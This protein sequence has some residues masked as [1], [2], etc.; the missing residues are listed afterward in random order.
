MVDF[1][2]IL[3]NHNMEALE[4]HLRKRV[5][6]V[7]I[8]LLLLGLAIGLYAS[9]FSYFTIMK[10]LGFRTYAWDLGIFNQALSTTL[11]NGRFFYYTPE[12]LVNPSGSFFGIHFSPILF[13]VLPFYA[14]FPASHTLL[15]IQSFI[16]ALGAVPLYKLSID[17][18]SHRVAALVFVFAY[19]L[20]PPLQGINWFDFHVQAFFPLL[21]FS[22]IY[23]FEKRSW[24]TYFLFILFSLMVEEHASL[25]VLFIGVYGLIRNKE[26]IIP[27]LRDKDLKNASLVIPIIT[28]V[29]AVLW[30]LMT[31]WVRD[32]FFPINPNFIY[33]FNA[34]ANWSVLGVQ[35]PL[36]IPF[37]IFLFP[38][39][40]IAALS[41]D[42]L[43]KAGYMLILF[44]PL[45]FKSFSSV[46]HLLPT[47]PWFVLALFSNYVA[48]YTIYN[49]YPAYVVAFVFTAAIFAL[50]EKVDLKI[51]K[52]DLEIIFLIS[53]AAFL[54]VSP[55]SP[56]VNIVFPDYGF[57]P[58]GDHESRLQNVLAFLP[59]NASVLTQ[60]N[61]FPH[62]SSRINAYTIPV[63]HQI[64]TM[65][66]HEFRNF[67]R[68]MIQKVEYILVDFQSDLFSS[69]LVFPLIKESQQFKVFASDDRIVLFKKDYMGEAKI[70]SPY[71]AT[72]SHSSLFL[73]SG[74]KIEDPDSISKTIM[75]FNGESGS[76]PLFWF[77][78]RC[79]LPPGNYSIT[80]RLKVDA[81]E[82]SSSEIFTVEFCSSN[83]QDIL[84]SKTFFDSDLSNSA[85]WENRTI[86][87]SL[88][89][90]LVDFET[91]AVNI[92]SPVHIY[93]DYIEVKQID[94]Q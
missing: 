38:S 19:L 45:A 42:F 61:I 74:E 6:N 51:L 17:V 7:E 13:L 22:T 93:L 90:P 65:R 33:E 39:R 11:N 84:I 71:R 14:I 21:F 57:R 79:L 4:S 53:L 1:L 2:S 91:R 41:Y 50:K 40:A 29:L 44:G 12:L 70:L 16:L 24:K 5:F 60:S 75:H 68:E 10:D 18:L 46:K 32:N 25:V 54:F 26:K 8:S 59:S 58:P 82:I 30:Y 34:A 28:A 89:K 72:F 64:W 9:V 88:D 92:S 55:I 20:Y 77:G 78:P 86:N 63:I 23:F 15:V 43:T 62:V 52:K 3:K 37:T 48:Y 80:L 76:S 66:A 47:L 94:S 31:F 85:T 67:T 87:I 35:T 36:L 69:G 27:I 81:I 83:G 73:Y 49:Q 56:V